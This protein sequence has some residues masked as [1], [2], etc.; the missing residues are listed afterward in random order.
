MPI[1]CG[2]PF[3]AVAVV[4]AQPGH[5]CFRAAAGQIKSMQDALCEAPRRRAG[6]HRVSAARRAPEP[7]NDVSRG[8]RMEHAHF[9][10]TL[11]DALY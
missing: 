1:R 5:L 6:R 9:S 4:L 10:L 11:V 2:L 7:P 3:L 8:Q